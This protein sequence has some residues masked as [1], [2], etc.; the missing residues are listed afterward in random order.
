MKYICVQVILDHLDCKVREASQGCLVCQDPLV[1]LVHQENG[2]IRGIEDQKE[3]ALRDLWDHE[4]YQV[5]P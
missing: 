1:I 5:W 3:L 4:D 2:E